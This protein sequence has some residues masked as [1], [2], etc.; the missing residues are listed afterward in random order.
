V[1]RDLADDFG[2]HATPNPEWSA[3]EKDM[4]GVIGLERLLEIERETVEPGLSS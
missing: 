4:F 3:L 2:A 1:Y